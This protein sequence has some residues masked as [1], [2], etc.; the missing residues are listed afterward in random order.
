MKGLNSL[1]YVVYVSAIII[2]QIFCGTRLVRIYGNNQVLLGKMSQVTI[3]MS[4][5][6]DF[7]YAINFIQIMMGS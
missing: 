1:L 5:I 6:I 2:V 4:S 7:T 3:G